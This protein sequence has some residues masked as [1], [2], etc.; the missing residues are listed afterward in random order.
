[1]KLTGNKR[2]KQPAPEKNPKASPAKNNE[3]SGKKADPANS[4]E[5]KP[6]KRRVPVPVIVICSILG[7]ILLGFGVFKLWLQPPPMPSPGLYKPTTPTPASSAAP[8]ET[9]AE[10]EAPAELPGKIYT[11]IVVGRDKV[12]AN[13]D[14]MMVVHFDTTAHKLNVVSIPRDTLVNIPENVKRV[15]TLYAYGKNRNGDGPARLK[16][17]LRDILGFELGNYVIV[18]LRAFEEIV[19]AIGGVTYNVPIDMFYDDPYQNLHIAIRRGEQLLSGAEALKV[20]RFRAGYASADIGRIGT[21][22]DFLKAVA[23]QLLTVGN[24]P[25]LPKIIDILTSNVETDLTA[26]NITY[27]ATELLK[28]KAEDITFNTLPADY[29]ANI[30]GFS[31]VSIYIPE[32]LDMVNTY[33]NPYPEKVT[34]ANVNILTKTKNGF[35]ST[36]GTVAGGPGSFLTLEAYLKASGADTPAATD[37]PPAE[38]GG[39]EA[40]PAEGGGGEAPPAEGGGGEAPPAEGGEG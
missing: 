20:V 13:T 35:Y 25:N 6:K 8:S 39:G 5:G 21:Q 1:M 15:N 16:E 12:G 34:E 22:Q 37:A 14:T 11:F 10:T 27:F 2:N 7:V 4:I 3:A 38:G 17:G 29:T 18:D 40:P 36:T 32:W 26:A 28:C 19:D 31:Y 23:K 24:I 9:P 33:L 30:G